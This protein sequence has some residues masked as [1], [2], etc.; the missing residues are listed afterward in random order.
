[1][2]MTTPTPATTVTYRHLEITERYRPDTDPP[3][4][5]FRVIAAMNASRRFWRSAKGVILFEAE[6]DFFVGLANQREL[7]AVLRDSGVIQWAGD[8]VP[9]DEWRMI[10]VAVMVYRYKIPAAS[11]RFA[12][13]APVQS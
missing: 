6:P 5:P 11:Q 10:A 12:K 3:G 2:H 9:D 7:V 8:P 1:M 13:P 4:L